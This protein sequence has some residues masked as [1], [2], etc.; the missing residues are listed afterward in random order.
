VFLG[1]ADHYEMKM[2][3]IGGT[4]AKQAQVA[5]SGLVTAPPGLFWV[6]WPTSLTSSSPDASRD[7]ILTLKKSQINLSSGRFLKGQNMQNNIFLSYRAITKISGVD[8][9]S[10]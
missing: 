10:P 7:K 6:S 8:G 3:D 4:R 1:Q 2:N 9:K 5:W